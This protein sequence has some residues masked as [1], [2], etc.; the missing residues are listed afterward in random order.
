MRIVYF[1]YTAIDPRKAQKLAAC[2]GPVTLLQPAP[3][4]SLPE[5]RALEEAGLIETLYPAADHS[6]QLTDYIKAFEEWAG[7][8]A[9]SDLAALMERGAPIPFFNDHSLAQIVAEL[10]SSAKSPESGAPGKISL[11]NI[12]QAQLLLAMAQK[13]DRQQDELAH[14]IEVLARKER[15]M[16]ALLKGEEE[17]ER[18]SLSAPWMPP[19]DQREALLD[20]RLKAW[21]RTMEALPER[22]KGFPGT[23]ADILFLTDSQGV[24]TQIQDIF[25][26]A[27]RRLAA[28]PLPAESLPAETIDMLPSWLAI[29]LTSRSASALGPEIYA[30]TRFDLI[31]IPGVPVEGFLR[32][33]AGGRRPEDGDPNAR[34]SAGSCWVGSLAWPGGAEGDA[35]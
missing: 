32:R 14:E 33:L 4:A 22:E 1:P 24:M 13:F 12:L 2:W 10:R 3:G 18:G 34:L 17:P 8:S 21:A 26:E 5:T 30:P 11:P 29:P 6:P 25:P 16:L 20:L 27:R 9:G 7:R 23:A 15:H 28:C 35:G 31:E 19:S